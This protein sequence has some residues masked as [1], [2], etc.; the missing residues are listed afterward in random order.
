[1]VNYYSAKER[2]TVAQQHGQIVVAID[3]AA[4]CSYRCFVDESKKHLDKITPAQPAWA[5]GSESCTTLQ[6]FFDSS[7]LTGRSRIVQVTSFAELVDGESYLVTDGH[8]RIDMFAA[9][10]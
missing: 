4:V 1:M 2:V 9:A 8:Q 5:A 10:K 3:A 7:R 6:C